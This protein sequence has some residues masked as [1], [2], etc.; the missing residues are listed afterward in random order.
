MYHILFLV[1]LVPCIKNLFG[2]IF[3]LEITAYFL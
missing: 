3:T 2:K 1:H